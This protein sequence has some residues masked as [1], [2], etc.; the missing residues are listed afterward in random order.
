MAFLLD[1]L[2]I[3]ILLEKIASNYDIKLKNHFL[4]LT[5][6]RKINFLKSLELIDD[7]TASGLQKINK[8]RNKFAHELGYEPNKG[9]LLN[10]I[11]NLRDN[12]S[13]MTGGLEQLHGALE[14][15]NTLQKSSEQYGCG[16]ADLFIQVV[17]DLEEYKIHEAAV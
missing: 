14:E 12:F 13:D 1:K 17:Y 10:L 8:M 16:L 7:G 5:H 2:V 15:C 4:S 11:S 9:E 3:E 6:S